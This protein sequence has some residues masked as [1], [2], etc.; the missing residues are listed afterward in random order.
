MHVTVSSELKFLSVA[1]KISN[2]SEKRI[3]VVGMK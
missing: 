3:V 1:S 2:F